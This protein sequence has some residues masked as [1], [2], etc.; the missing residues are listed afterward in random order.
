MR[1]GMDFSSFDH[2][3][4]HLRYKVGPLASMVLIPMPILTYFSYQHLIYIHLPVSKKIL[5]SFVQ[6]LVDLKSSWKDM[7]ELP[8]ILQRLHVISDCVHFVLEFSARNVQ[9]GSDKKLLGS[10][11]ELVAVMDT[12]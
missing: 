1:L 11:C 8:G 6:K 12:G 7:Q 4:K 5:W 10:K 3:E 2:M 9:E